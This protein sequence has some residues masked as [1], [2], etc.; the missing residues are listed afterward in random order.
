MSKDADELISQLR[1]AALEV[2]EGGISVDM[3]ID[4]AERFGSLVEGAMREGAVL[5]RHVGEEVLALHGEVLAYL[6]NLRNGE[7][8]RLAREFSQRRATLHYLKVKDS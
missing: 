5:P 2:F 8:V 3:V 6:G 7:G 1:G 4:R